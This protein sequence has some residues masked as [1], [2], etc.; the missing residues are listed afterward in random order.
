MA[1]LLDFAPVR[2]FTSNAA[3]GAGYIARFFQS[4]TTTPVTVFANS[5]LS[6][7]LGTSV[8]A[9]AEGKFVAVFSA[10]G[11]IKATIE[12]PT[13][14]VVATVDPVQS[15]PASSSSAENV[16]FA[17]SAL[18]PQT[19]V[20][21]AIALGTFPARTI[22]AGENIAVTN[23]NGASGNPTISFNRG[24]PVIKTADFTV[25]AAE[26]WLINNKS[27]SA[28]VVTLPAAAT[29]TG[30]EIMFQN[31]QAQAVNSATSNVIPMAGGA[32]AAAI[33]P[34]VIGSR[35]T[36]ISDGTSWRV[37]DYYLP[38]LG[39]GQAWTDVTG[40]RAIATT[41][42]NTTGRPIM[43]ALQHSLLAGVTGNFLVA[44]A[45]VSQF[46]NNGTGGT[47]YTHNVI[48]PAGATYSATNGSISVW[49]ELR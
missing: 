35:A 8:T 44:G 2:V 24:A 4:G 45:T 47:S 10:G 31:L 13:G 34:A 7:P 28:C 27:G 37:V 39:D 43:V 48:V 14:S 16:T 15:V 41:Y 40:S 29:A 32:A 11:A 17:P 9:D 19:N 30:R 23:G 20:Q 42:T 21:D 38:Q 25:A 5:A 33:L 6:T 22:T 12:T 36:L 26:S 49:R 18:R 1:D 3:P 46:A